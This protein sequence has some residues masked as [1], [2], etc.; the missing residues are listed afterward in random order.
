LQTT[1]ATKISL[2]TFNKLQAILVT[3][4]KG[5]G[6][7]KKLTNTSSSFDSIVYIIS[8][9]IKMQLFLSQLKANDVL[10]HVPI[11]II[12][13]LLLFWNNLKCSIQMLGWSYIMTHG[14][15]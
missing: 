12:I 8:H 4:N 13:I 6:W 9:A 5:I 14:P 3:N 7:K 2:V 10:P 15:M 1:F 11:L